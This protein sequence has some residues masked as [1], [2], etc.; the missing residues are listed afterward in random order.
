[1]SH[2]VTKDVTIVT[3]KSHHMSW[4]MILQSLVGIV[5]KEYID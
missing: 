4:H 5:G 3:R 1:M 2:F